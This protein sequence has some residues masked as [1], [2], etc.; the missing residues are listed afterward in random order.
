MTT[1]V[2]VTSGRHWRCRSIHRLPPREE[3]RHN[4]AES[5]DNAK[6]GP[7]VA[8]DHRDD[9]AAGHEDGA[10]P[11][12]I[13]VEVDAVEEVEEAEHHGDDLSAGRAAEGGDDGGEAEDAGKYQDNSAEPVKGFA[14]GIFAGDFAGV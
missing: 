2:S 1:S 14:A 7:A 12:E 6:A 4:Q 11:E 10:E 3:C 5:D 13:A 9:D 8:R